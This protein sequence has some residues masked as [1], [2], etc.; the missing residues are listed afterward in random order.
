MHIGGESLLND[1]SSVAFFQISRSLYLAQIG[2][3]SVVGFSEG[4]VLFVK[5]CFGG[6]AI[7]LVCAIVQLVL[8][9]ELD[10]KLEP[11]YNV[12]QV[13]LSVTFAYLSY[14][15][16]DQV[17]QFSGILSCVVCCITVSA[18]GKGLINDPHLMGNYTALMQQLL[19]TLLFT[20]GGSVFGSIISGLRSH[21]L[22]GTDWGYL[23]VLVVL[24]EIMRYVQ[25][26]ACYPLISRI[27]LET[28]VK[29]S[30]FLGF[31]GIRGAV[32]IALSVSLLNSVNE[33]LLDPLNT[34][35]V[36]ATD[37]APAIILV[38]MSGGVSFATL[39]I[40]ASLAGPMLQWLGLSQPKQS[41]KRETDLWKAEASAFVVREYQELIQHNQLKGVIPKVVR[42]HLPFVKN[43]GTSN[44]SFDSVL[45]VDVTADTV[46]QPV[47]PTA[48]ADYESV[49][50]DWQNSVRTSEDKDLQASDSSVSEDDSEQ[51]EPPDAVQIELRGMFV[52]FLR[53]AYTKIALTGEMDRKGG[54]GVED[55]VSMDIKSLEL[56]KLESIVENEGVSQPKLRHAKF[57]DRILRRL[58]LDNSLI[59]RSEEPTSIDSVRRRIICA[60]AFIRAHEIAEAKLVSTVNNFLSA[61]GE[62]SSTGHQAKATQ[63][64]AIAILLESQS[65]VQA[66]QNG[67]A[68]VEETKLQTIVSHYVVKVLCA[69]LTKYVEKSMEDGL[70]SNKEAHRYMDR[71]DRACANARNCGIPCF[72]LRKRMRTISGR[73]LSWHGSTKGRDLSWHGSAKS[74][75]DLA[76]N[77]GA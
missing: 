14:Y 57:V 49:I 19:N 46:C 27:G 52:K 31:C 47:Q 28:N 36:N 3:G 77:V 61:D 73:D 48:V 53:D 62:Y 13:S 34:D 43:W 24:V 10:R 32:G 38:F 74:S 71:V 1:G 7:G 12:L 59:G 45:K 41:R 51:D 69:K 70:L 35:I 64:A 40:N 29:E 67:L 23:V 63:E 58:Q 21:A 66:A 5:M 17:L 20:L 50:S 75:T 25:V 26:F 2:V 44:D 60:L 33:A 22:T 42:M 39:L 15:L 4:V 56:D 54:V 55:M 16:A 6:I 8:L 37:L 30:A 65:Y 11:E 18:L 72:T 9:Y 68:N 76:S